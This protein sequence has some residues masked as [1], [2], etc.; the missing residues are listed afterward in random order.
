MTDL[1]TWTHRSLG[2]ED[3]VKP[4][5][6]EDREQASSTLPQRG[7]LMHI[8]NVPSNMGQWTDS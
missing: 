7:S 5:Q 2:L 6:A 1:K 3:L 8:H 4:R